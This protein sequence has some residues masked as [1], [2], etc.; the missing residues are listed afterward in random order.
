MLRR[1]VVPLSIAVLL[2]LAPDGRGQ[3][4]LKQKVT[5]DSSH[6]FEVGQF[7]TQLLTINGTEIKTEVDTGMTLVTSTGRR[8]AD[9]QIEQKVKIDSLRQN[10]TIPGNSTLTYDSSINLAKVDNEGLQFILDALKTLTGATYTLK[11]DRD[12]RF[13]GASGADE[14]LKDA[15]P[16]AAELLKTQLASETLKRQHELERQRWPQ[17]PVRPGDTWERVEELDL[18]AG[19]IMTVERLYEYQGTE[20]RGDRTLHNIAATDKRIIGLQAEATNIRPFKIRN[21]DLKV[22]ESKNTILFDVE[23]GLEVEN[24]RLLHIKGKLSLVINDT[25]LPTELDL[26]IDSTV[27]LKGE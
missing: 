14:I 13:V 3:V 19:Q 5:E 15:P 27:R 23:R 24:N 21:P 6:A 20:Q 18:G 26:K 22:A 4:E 2:A 17:Q 10:L 9:G 16:M 25:E 8:G 11:L 7:M 12:G 1:A